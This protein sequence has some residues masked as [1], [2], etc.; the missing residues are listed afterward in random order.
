[1]LLKTGALAVV[2]VLLATTGQLLLKAGMER[3]GYV[4]GSRLDQPLELIL[5]V[6]RTP[7]IVVGLGLF[8]ISAVFWLVV[9]SRAPLSF[10][11]PFAGLTYVLT[12]VFARYVLGEHVPGIRWVGIV[13][14]LTGIVVVGRTAP[15]QIQ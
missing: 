6:A 9:L 2:S 3:V 12:T 5:R 8:G 7:Q 10:A 14:I 1:M 11:Y 13:L 15:P 4:G